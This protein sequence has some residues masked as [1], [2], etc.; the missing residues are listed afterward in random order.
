MN[1]NVILVRLQL[2]S[3]FDKLVSHAILVI[4]LPVK[5]IQLSKIK[6]TLCFHSV[7][8]IARVC[9]THVKS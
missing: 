1:T 5:I 7:T 8:N 6:V 9:F 3:R 4:V 2:T